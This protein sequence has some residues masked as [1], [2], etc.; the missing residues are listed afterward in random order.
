[1]DPI[2][3]CYAESL[4]GI[5]HFQDFKKADYRLRNKTSQNRFS[6]TIKWKDCQMDPGIK[7]QVQPWYPILVYLR[8]SFQLVIQDSESL[9]NIRLCWISFFIP[10]EDS[11]SV[12]DYFISE[13]YQ[14]DPDSFHGSSQKLIFHD[15]RMAAGQF[16]S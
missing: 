5:K 8:F 1:M 3:F 6:N 9:H 12:L 14:R 10:I 16:K 11:D 4:R 15:F 13:T 2:G 7:S